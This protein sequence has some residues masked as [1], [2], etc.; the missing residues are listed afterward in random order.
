VS[1]VDKADTHVYDDIADDDAPAVDTGVSAND[2]EFEKC[3]LCE[4]VRLFPEKAVKHCK[5]SNMQFEGMPGG[6]NTNDGCKDAAIFS[7]IRE[8]F[9]S[10][11]SRENTKLPTSEN[12]MMWNLPATT[13]VI[14]KNGF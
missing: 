13:T 1:L 5:N 3:E 2:Y 11:A 8:F 14:R 7:M 4:K 6:H 10:P 12:S 9:S